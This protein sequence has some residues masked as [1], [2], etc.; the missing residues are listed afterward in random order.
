MEKRKLA[1]T[2]LVTTLVAKAV[3]KTTLEKR[4]VASTA[5]ISLKIFTSKI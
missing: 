5:I 1:I 4:D 2:M 3:D